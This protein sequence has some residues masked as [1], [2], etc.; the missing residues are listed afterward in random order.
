MGF[1]IKKTGVFGG[2]NSDL[3]GSEEWLDKGK[4][5]EDDSTTNNNEHFFESDNFQS[6]INSTQKGC[7]SNIGTSVSAIF[8]CFA[9]FFVF[10]KIK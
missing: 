9:V 6:D 3:S 5:E 7:A 2:D 8:V 1:K 4:N 10:R